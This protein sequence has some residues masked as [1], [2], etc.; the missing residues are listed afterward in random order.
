MIIPAFP[1]SFYHP[2]HPLMVSPAVAFPS[3]LLF[4][5][6]PI[7]S[8][9]CFPVSFAVFASIIT[10][11]S[12]NSLSIG[13]IAFKRSLNVACEAGESN[14]CVSGMRGGTSSFGDAGSGAAV[15]VLLLSLFGTGVAVGGFDTEES[16][17]ANCGSGSP[18]ALASAVAASCA[19]MR[20]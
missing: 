13:V 1:G 6:C 2:N 12:S 3:S 19:S 15:V 10:A 14:V 11:L 9:T 18:A 17:G 7:I 16:M 8:V 5:L 20:W 4:F